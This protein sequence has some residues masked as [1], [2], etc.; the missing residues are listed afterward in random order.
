MINKSV[1]YLLCIIFSLTFVKTI[2]ADEFTFDT[3]EIIISE[4]GN[5]F[6]SEKGGVVTTSNDVKIYADQFEYNKISSIL[7]AT[8]NVILLD[9]ENKTETKSNKI[10]YEKNQEVITAVG[11]VNFFDKRKNLFLEADKTIYYRKNDIFNAYNNVKINDKSNQI[12]LETNEIIY[13]RRKEEISSI[14]STKIFIGN[15]YTVNTSDITFQRNNGKIFSNKFTD[16][17]DKEDYYYYSAENFRYFLKTKTFRGKNLYVISQENDKYYFEDGMI[18]LASKEIIGKDLVTYFNKKF[19]DERNEPRLKGNIGFSD[20]EKT[21]VTKGAFTTCKSRGDKCPPW[22]IEAKEVEHDKKKKIVYYKNAWLKVYN[23][24]VVYYPRFFHPDPTV[25]RQSG[26]LK[27]S[28]SESQNLGSSI[29]LPY[30]YV[31]SESRDMTIKP[32]FYEDDKTVL[33]AEFRNITKNT[34]SITDFSFTSGHKSYE[35]DDKDSRGH[36][37]S[38]SIINFDIDQY[39]TSSLEINLEKSTNDTYLKLFNLES[40]LLYDRDLGTLN[41]QITF[42]ADKEDLNISSSIS[43]YEKMNP[44]IADKYEF[45][46]PDFSLSKNIDTLDYPGFLDFTSTGSSYLYESNKSETKLTN[47]LVYSS[48]KSILKNG[49]QSD[50]NILFKNFNSIGSNSSGFESSLNN[51]FLTTFLH[52]SSYPLKKSGNLFDSYLTPKITFRYSPNGMNQN[53]NNGIDISNIFANNR[54]GTSDTFES[55]KSLTFGFEYDKE[56]NSDESKIFNA[57]LGTIYRLNYE[58]KLGNNNSMNKEKTDVVGKI[59]LNPFSNNYLNY[60][61]AMSDNLNTFNSHSINTQISINNFVTKFDYI[62]DFVG[63]NSKHSL[64]NETRYIFNNSSSIGFSTSEN[65]KINFTEFYNTYYQY[66]ND[67]LTARLSYN[68]SYYEDR[69]IK[70]SENLFFSISIVPLG[71]YESQN[72][73]GGF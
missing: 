33:Q 9:E 13:K 5:Q 65:K 32:R 2:V 25:E 38:N 46:F 39:D 36:L 56:R 29:Y 3:P 14:N 1:K 18:D 72:V 62:E 10:I 69:D 37:F 73:L 40:P 58:E 17:E 45:I 7:T 57:N 63:N 16:L 11:N 27:P 67:C 44:T 42:K 43:V 64:K 15:K 12:I 8:G 49:I 60:N 23:I 61:F 55:G 30:F 4:D 66:Q 47:D 6:R 54:I 59:G 48:E 26:F 53:T 20:P 50:Y 41:S 34:Y 19:T 68:K 70:P 21:K 71:A 31:L 51:E 22:V 24:P 52:K 28:A 35:E